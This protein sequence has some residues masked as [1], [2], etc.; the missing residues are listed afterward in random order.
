[1]MKEKEQLDIIKDI[2]T[3][4]MDPLEKLQ[5][6]EEIVFGKKNCGIEEEE[7]I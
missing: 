3:R 5:G 4:E 6:I 2:L 1:M 7:I